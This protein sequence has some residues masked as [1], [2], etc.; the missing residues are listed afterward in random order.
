M[1]LS[2]RRHTWQTSSIGCFRGSWW[3]LLDDGRL[4]KCAKDRQ[5]IAGKLPDWFT[6]HV[7]D[8]SL[9]IFQVWFQVM[10]P[11]S[12]LTQVYPG[13]VTSETCINLLVRAKS[14]ILSYLSLTNVFAT[15]FASGPQPVASPVGLSCR[16]SFFCIGCAQCGIGQ[17]SCSMGHAQLASY[18]NLSSIFPQM[19]VLGPLKLAERF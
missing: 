11:S 8:Y 1:N 13:H 12:C 15:I 4:T 9:K 19:W 18:Q 14:S 16:K 17:G 2:A 3:M 10:E 5:E 7:S 6:G